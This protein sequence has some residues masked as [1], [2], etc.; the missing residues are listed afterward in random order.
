MKNDVL[1]T[2]SLSKN[3]S[4]NLQGIWDIG[5]VPSFGVSVWKLLETH[6]ITYSRDLSKNL[7][8][9]LDKINWNN[10]RLLY[11]HKLVSV[12]LDTVK[13]T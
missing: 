11:C 3:K 6:Y 4:V 2:I 8:I 10:Y 12:T 7:F 5:A 1:K 9:A 13:I